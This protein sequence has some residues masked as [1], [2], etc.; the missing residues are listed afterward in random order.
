[1]D[2]PFSVTY[3]ETFT[4]TYA[5]EVDADIVVRVSLHRH[6]LHGHT[7]YSHTFNS[8]T[9][10]CTLHSLTLHG[11]TNKPPFSFAWGTAREV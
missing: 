2:S 3:G 8:H 9:R 4:V 7:F 6:T 5:G 1:M 11:H 10:S